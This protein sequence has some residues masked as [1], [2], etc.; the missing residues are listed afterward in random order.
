MYRKARRNAELEALAEQRDK[1]RIQL[2]LL[3]DKRTKDGPRVCEMLTQL[4]E[5][6]WQISRHR[7][8]LW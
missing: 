1:L 8:Q 5:L 3:A 4:F 7:R 2:S 6:E